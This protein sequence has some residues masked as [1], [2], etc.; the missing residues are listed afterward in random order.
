MNIDTPNSIVKRHNVHVCGAG[1]QPILFAH[2]LGCDQQVWRP[3]VPAF[4]KEYKIITF[5]Y[6][7]SGASDFSAYNKQKYSKL[8]GYAADI[9]ELCTAL[10]LINVIFIGHSVSSMIG[11]LAAIKKP[12]LFKCLIMIGPSPCYLND[13]G[14]NGGFE[15]SEIDALLE[16]MAQ[17]FREWAGFFAPRVMGN[18]TDPNLTYNL[19]N[20][21]CSADPEITLDFANVTFRSDNRNDLQKLKTP[22]LILQTAED[23]VAPLAVGAYMHAQTPGST[24]VYMKAT[25][26]FPHLS[27]PGET[28][29][30]IKRYLEMCS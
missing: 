11:L 20:T 27:A 4:E 28:I 8:E 14:Y 25:G 24:I 12:V 15:K 10:D 21:F 2:G 16:L 1:N 7:G 5:D 13:K 26:H 17:N 6:V 22:C 30:E 19:K 23:I 18:Q 3:L 29:K 9:I